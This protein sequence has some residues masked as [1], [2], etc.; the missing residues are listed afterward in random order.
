M[1]FYIFNKESHK[2][3]I[4][5]WFSSIF[6]KH[7]YPFA[8]CPG[9]LVVILLSVLVGWRPSCRWPHRSGSRMI[10]RLLQLL[11]DVSQITVRLLQLLKDVSQIAARLLQLV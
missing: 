3:E 11:K 8:E 10:A 1:Y 2:N 4:L 6:A 9:G 7:A 5:M